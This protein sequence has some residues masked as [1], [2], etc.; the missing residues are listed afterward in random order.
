MYKRSDTDNSY[1]GKTQ[2]FANRGG[3]SGNNINASDVI[4][5]YHVTNHESDCGVKYTIPH[6][7]ERQRNYS[8]PRQRDYSPPRQRN[9]SPPSWRNHS[10]TRQRNY[11]PPRQRNYS[12]PTWRNHSPTRQRNY[13]PPRQ[14]NYSPPT[15][16]NHSPTRQR[17]YSPPR[18]RNYSPPRQRNYSPPTWRNYSP[19]RQRNYSPPRQRNYS[20]PRQRNYSPPRQSSPPRQRDYSPPRQRNY[21]PPKQK[22]YSSS[23]LREKNYTLPSIAPKDF[24]SSELNS[25]SQLRGK[26]ITKII[27][28]PPGELSKNGKRHDN[29]FEKISDISIIPTKEEV[30][31]GRRPFLPS[32]LPN[33]P[34][35]LPDGMARLLDTQFRLLREDM[36]NV[37]RSGVS[38]FITA[39]LNDW[40]SS[41]ND[42]I[43]LKN[44]QERGGRFKYD[45]T[46]DI[47]VYTGIQFVDIACD[48]E[49]GFFCT[50]RFTPLNIPSEKNFED[51]KEY[52]KKCKK[53][54]VGSLVT[55]L[56]PNQNITQSQS[57]DSTNNSDLFSLYFGVV[58]TRNVEELAGYD[59]AVIGINFI[60]SSIYSIALDEALNFDN[61]IKQSLEK[62][63]MLESTGVY[64]ESYYHTL[65]TLKN[66]STNPSLLPFKKYLAPN[67]DDLNNKGKIIDNPLYTRVPGFKFDLS[68][69]CKN[70]EINLKL[71]V[72]DTSNHGEVAKNVTKHSKL[73][74][75]QGNYLYNI[76]FVLKGNRI[77]LSKT[78]I[79]H[80]FNFQL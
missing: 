54:Q 6:H 37:V 74:K 70:K 27:Y 63:F 66:Q 2:I 30:L 47:Q 44:I 71:N 76:I 79:N 26:V 22:N 45:N 31:C 11:S 65:N 14:R 34:H 59:R 38:N 33:T 57:N 7:R 24:S 16:R 40:S 42:N 80:F 50:I 23:S 29:D 39:L 19:P 53:L 18:Q 55:L 51:R 5:N 48:R 10:P 52:W 9:Y 35:F 15:W 67:L 49:K 46:N 32:S 13:S 77:N 72:A 36:L 56:L 4:D 73:Y 28:D 41:S 12:P 60:D 8:P 21:S 20:P 62:R 78:I 69:L 17:N 3:G 43:E 61:I 25:K 58:V 64:L 68:V 75:T 1:N